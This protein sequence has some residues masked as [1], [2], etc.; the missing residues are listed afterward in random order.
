MINKKKAQSEIITVIL[1]IL[2]VLAAIVIVWQV[3][4]RTIATT[5]EKILN[6]ESCVGLNLR[7]VSASAPIGNCL[8]KDA[9][10]KDCPD[11]NEKVSGIPNG[12]DCK[13]TA[14]NLEYGKTCDFDK[15]EIDLSNPNNNGKVVV[16]RES[17]TSSV[18]EIEPVLLINGQLS[19]VTFDPKKIKTLETATA[20]GGPLNNVAKGDSVKVAAKMYNGNLCAESLEI[21]FN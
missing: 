21:K 7:V 12:T 14:I 8:Y 19:P 20:K 3:V 13:D 4:S 15:W 9:V 16:Q 6:E 5:R 1:I 18:E 10:G 2:L 11:V 17:G